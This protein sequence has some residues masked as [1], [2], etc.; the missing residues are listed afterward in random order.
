MFR[1]SSDTSSVTSSPAHA[2]AA[3]AA[4]PAHREDSDYNGQSQVLEQAYSLLLAYCIDSF[5]SQCVFIV[6][7]YNNPPLFL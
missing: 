5:Q 1:S 6:S 2:A 4:S 7:D 3:T